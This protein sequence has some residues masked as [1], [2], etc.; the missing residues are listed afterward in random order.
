LLVLNARVRLGAYLFLQ[1]FML[2]IWFV[3]L[4]T[5]MSQTLQFDSVIGLAYAAQGI[6]AIIASPFI[7]ALADRLIPARRLLAILMAFSAGSLF[8]LASIRDNEVAFLGVVLIHFLAFVPTI[9][10]TNAICLNALSEPERD[11]ARLRVLGTVGWIAG[12]VLIGLITNALLTP[13]PI[14]IAGAAGLVLSISAR[15]LPDL[16]IS[17]EKSSFSIGKALGLD[18]LS[19]IKNRS[20]WAVSAC[21]L[22]LSIPLAFYNAY[23]NNFL[24]ESG[25][26][27]SLLG[28]TLEPTAIQAF[29]QGSELFF[30]LLLPF[31]LR[32]IGIGGVLVIGMVGWLLR[33]TLFVIG[34]SAGGDSSLAPIMAGILLHGVCYDFILIGAALYVDKAVARSARSRAQ[35]FLTMITMGVGITLGSLISNAVYNLATTSEA[36]RDWDMIWI[37]S[38]AMAALA[39]VI[40]LLTFRDWRTPPRTKPQAS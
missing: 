3:A 5:Y 23:C 6:A 32:V 35:S 2:G 34:Y 28:T 31:V 40:F 20:F 19:H 26:R 38:G 33:S 39:L 36:A 8:L 1:Y 22:L 14:I 7:G 15:Y 18:A 17:A 9:P 11:F 16:P 37:T 10:L 25:A 30:L 24:Q 27:L 21:A 13:L 12:G 29:G 4:G